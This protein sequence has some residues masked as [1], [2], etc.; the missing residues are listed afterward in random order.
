M[1]TTSTT[2]CTLAPGDTEVL[3]RWKRSKCDGISGS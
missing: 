2:Q 1:D 3:D